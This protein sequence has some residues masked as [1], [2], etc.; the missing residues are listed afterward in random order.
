MGGN[1]DFPHTMVTAGGPGHSQAQGKVK[2]CWGAST[3]DKLSTIEAFSHFRTKNWGGGAQIGPPG[4]SFSDGPVS[5]TAA[6]S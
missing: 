1:Y 6:S 2:Q 4:T 5:A 3:I